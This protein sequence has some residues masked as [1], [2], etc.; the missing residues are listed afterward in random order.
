MY[1][2]VLFAR[3]VSDAKKHAAGTEKNETRRSRSRPAPTRNEFADLSDDDDENRRIT[4]R[5][6]AA[7]RPNGY[8]KQTRRVE[9]DR[10][11]ETFRLRSRVYSFTPGRQLDDG[12]SSS[13]IS[14]EAALPFTLYNNRVGYC[15]WRGQVSELAFDY[16]DN[17]SGN[18]AVRSRTRPNKMGIFGRDCASIRRKA[19]R[20]R[21]RLISTSVFSKH[22]G[23]GT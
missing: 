11:I 3:N 19:T 8:D 17:K 13:A 14:T 2:G 21:R 9:L 18:R 22:G 16:R 6:G 7:L 15:D 10:N 23:D 4:E 12:G 1:T 5:Y 20:A